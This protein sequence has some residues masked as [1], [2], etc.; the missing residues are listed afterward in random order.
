M[1]SA[2][3][4]YKKDGI[5]KSITCRSDGEPIILGAYLRSN[6]AAKDKAI[7][8]VDDGPVEY[9]IARDCPK[10]GAGQ[11]NS[12]DK[13]GKLLCGIGINYS[14]LYIFDCEVEKWFIVKR[15]A[16]RPIELTDKVVGYN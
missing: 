10:D 7:K 16:H 1:P 13:L 11:T 4:S 14:Y 8:L 9:V 6:F 3:I 2:I 15:V 12:Y 5:Y